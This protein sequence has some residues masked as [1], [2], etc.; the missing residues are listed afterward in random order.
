M[1]NAVPAGREVDDVQRAQSSERYGT[2]PRVR[3][4]GEYSGRGDCGGDHVAIIP[5]ASTIA[6]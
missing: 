5:L 2:E 6:T 1:G 4:T 3:L